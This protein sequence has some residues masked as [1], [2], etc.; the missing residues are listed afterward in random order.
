MV[1]GLVA[2]FHQTTEIFDLFTIFL[3]LTNAICEIILYAELIQ[4][5]T[6]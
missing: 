3:S 1:V 4:Q 2:Q 5:A 6:W